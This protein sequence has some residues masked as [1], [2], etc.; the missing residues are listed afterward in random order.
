M[1]KTTKEENP[2]KLKVMAMVAAALAAGTTAE[3]G[4]LDIVKERGE[5]RCGVSQGVLGFSAPD[6][7]GAW[8]AV[9]L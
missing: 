9:E 7:N 3:A 4:T 5:V 6:K 2:M 8:I 1:P